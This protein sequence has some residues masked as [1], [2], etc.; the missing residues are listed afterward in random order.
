MR[1]LVL[2]V[3]T[4]SISRALGRR[5]HLLDGWHRAFLLL[6]L[7]RDGLLF[8]G[9]L[10]LLLLLWC[11]V[12]ESLLS[13]GLHGLGGNLLLCLCGGRLLSG[14]SRRGRRRLLVFIHG[15]WCWCWWWLLLLLVFVLFANLILDMWW[16]LLLLLL[17][18]LGVHGRGRGLLWFALAHLGVPLLVLLPLYL[19]RRLLLHCCLPGLLLVL[20]VLLSGGHSVVLGLHLDD[21]LLLVLTLFVVRFEGGLLDPHHAHIALLLAV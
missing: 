4:N 14:C 11:L 19:H 3:T 8:E 17:L 15:S 12:G 20:L 13:C 16:L 9:L 5:I 1:R 21:A 18:L 2:L 6:L 10:L 7:L